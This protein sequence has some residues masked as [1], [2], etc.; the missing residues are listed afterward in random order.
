M[1]LLR[2]VTL[3][4]TRFEFRLWT[5]NIIRELLNSKRGVKLSKSSVSR[6]LVH[7]GL[8]LQRPIYKSYQQDPKKIEH[9][10]N[11]TFPAVAR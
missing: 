2:W 7:L 4:I 9:Y 8:S 1:M 10:V 11:K 5:L 6:F 3:K